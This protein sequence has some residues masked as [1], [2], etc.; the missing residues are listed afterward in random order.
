MDNGCWYTCMEQCSKQYSHNVCNKECN[1]S[2]A[3]GVE[4]YKKP[5]NQIS[6]AL[7]GAP[8]IQ[9]ALQASGPA[10]IKKV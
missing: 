1:N 3:T 2:C 8:S 9:E 10:F 7:Y 5:A 4:M 6:S